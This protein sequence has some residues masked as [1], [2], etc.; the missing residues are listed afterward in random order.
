V[1]GIDRPQIDDTAPP[2]AKGD[3]VTDPVDPQGST[4]VVTSTTAV[5]PGIE[6]SHTINP[7]DGFDV[8]RGPTTDAGGAGDG[9][10][11][12][13]SAATAADASPDSS[14]DAGSVTL[15]GSESSSGIQTVSDDS[16]GTDVGVDTQAP[17]T[18]DLQI[19]DVGP[20]VDDATAPVDDVSFQPPADSFSGL[21]LPN[22]LAVP[23]QV[24]LDDGF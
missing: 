12:S 16:A 19:A 22:D 5:P 11:T 10:A 1:H 15:V 13:S 6:I 20:T 24:D 23:D 7:A 3:L 4:E 8:V 18:D 17:T 21:D 2:A 14:G 9:Y